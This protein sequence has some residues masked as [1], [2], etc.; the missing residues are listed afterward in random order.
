MARSWQTVRPGPRPRSRAELL[1]GAVVIAVS[2]YVIGYPLFVVRYPPITDLPFHASG[3]S[4]LRHY[5]DPAFGF[6]EQFSLHLLEVPYVSMYVIGALFALV[7]PM[8]VA[9]KAAAF[10]MLALLP[11][12]LAVMFHGLRKTPLWG[13]LGLAAV[14][15]NLTHWG[16][17]NFMGALGLYA[18]AVGF[19]LLAVDRPSRG[20]T[21]GLGLSLLAV[22]FT[23]IYRFP[24]ALLSV[25]GVGLLF[26]PA[27]RRIRPIL[28]ALL[29]SLLVFGV[30]RAIRPESIAE[31]GMQLAFDA[32]RWREVREHV[33][34][35]FAGAA[36]IE[37]QR[38]F[39]DFLGAALVVLLCTLFWRVFLRDKRSRH[40]RPLSFG[41]GQ[42]ML[43]LCLCA[44]YALAYFVMPMR[45]GI[46]WYVYPREATS[47]LLVLLALMPDMPRLWY[48]RAAT[49]LFMSFFVGKIGFFVAEQ[50]FAFEQA[51]ADFRAVAA[52]VSQNPRLMYLVFDHA[53]SSRRVTPFIHLPA[54]IQ[55]EK[56]GA[57]SFHF[58]GW[59]QSPIRYRV[60]SPAVPPPVPDRWE[61][62]PQ[63]F[64]L[65]QHGAF[66]DTFLV[67]S[68][69]D[70][71][72]LFR[73]DPAIRQVS[74]ESSWWLYQRSAP[75]QP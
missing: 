55:A 27:T 25:A 19:A 47:A 9:V 14:W 16:F 66:F 13:V 5:W 10:V 52:D 8:H 23:H 74:H 30:W 50:Y 54:W 2:I 31:Q 49:V 28:L 42:L 68:T 7:L 4:I 67:R 69:A 58:S 60:D 71:G 46:W 35:G 38:V 6:H 43:P 17:L 61:W 53:G 48:L 36:G 57:L 3:M 39:D 32:N 59:N 18:M 51:T 72:H 20:H 33:V 56:G 64:R 73:G 63:R 12:G 37:E 44:G 34:A 40:Q 29:P 21:V 75:A 22:F 70:P 1:L 24:F 11:T 45:I 62:T 41:F 15:T 26:Y 65:E